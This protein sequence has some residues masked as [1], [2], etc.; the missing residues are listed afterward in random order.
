[1]CAC[2]LELFRLTISRRNQKHSNKRNSAIKGE[3][4][5]CASSL[6]NRVGPY[7]LRWRLAASAYNKLS[8]FI[9]PALSLTL[10][11]IGPESAG[12]NG[13]YDASHDECG[14]CARTSQLPRAYAKSGTKT[15][16]RSGQP[17]VAKSFLF[18][19]S[20]LST[21]SKGLR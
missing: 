1:M 12:L 17:Q 14:P 13:P 15:M 6:R 8:A 7:S 11:T 4:V 9:F 2:C 19:K 18:P 20:N 21:K 3:W 5:R 16:S 10:Y